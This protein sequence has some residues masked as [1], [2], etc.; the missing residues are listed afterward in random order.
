MVVC[1]LTFTFERGGVITYF[2]ILPKHTLTKTIRLVTSCGRYEVVYVKICAV[3]DLYFVGIV[4]AVAI[5]TCYTCCDVFCLSNRR[6]S[7]YMT[8][9]KHKLLYS[10]GNMCPSSASS[11]PTTNYFFKVAF[12]CLNNW[13]TVVNLVTNSPLISK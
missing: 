10:G 1:V 9:L 11:T 3:L 12:R 13:I 8:L 7:S 2:Y 4:T 6:M 5:E